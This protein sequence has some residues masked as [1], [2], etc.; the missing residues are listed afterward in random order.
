M[1]PGGLSVLFVFSTRAMGGMEAR[2][3][4]VAR[5]ARARG[6]RALFA[7]TPGSTLDG[8]LAAAGVP[9]TP[10][11]I[12]GS[13]DLAAALR[14][15]RRIRRDRPDLVMAFSGKDYWMT[16]LA[17]R[18][19][20]IP[21]VL[22]RSTAG[23]L[24]SISVP[25]VSRADAV[26]AVSR[27]IKETLVAQGLPRDRIEV[28]YNGVNTEEFSP[29]RANP[30][31]RVRDALGIPREAF[32]VGCP[33]RRGKGQEDLLASASRLMAEGV[34]IHCL[35]AG[36]GIPSLIETHLRKTSP[37]LRSRVTARELIA[38]ERMP[39]IL[40]ALDVVVS[41]PEREPFSNLV[42]EA[43][44]MERP[45]ILS[46]TLGN[47]EA[48]EDGVSGIL[49]APGDVDAISGWLLR[50]WREPGLRVTL[51]RE[52][53]ERVRRRFSEPA[54]MEALEVAWGRAVG[55]RHPDSSGRGAGPNH[56]SD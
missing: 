22:N 46:R 34:P 27:G 16:I 18:L 28:I 9:R 32:L 38:R 37:A 54:M 23:A 43:M 11:H 12:H 39:D 8:R 7:C 30:R 14:L 4:R 48:V 53:G 29:R 5:L 21:V 6:H 50:L 17:A 56:S 47:I 35:F 24:R 52:A 49:V 31:D 36:E 19:A 25:V 2:A 1:K 26:L 15:Y 42:L 13:L 44:A 45:L 51:G 20:G 10:L 41:T 55:L 33:G 3:V 40:H